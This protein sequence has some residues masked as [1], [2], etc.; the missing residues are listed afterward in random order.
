[1][2]TDSTA[3]GTA[4]PRGQLVTRFGR[5]DLDS[6]DCITFP[7]GLPGFEHCRRYA[8]LKSPEFEPLVCLH[9]VEGEPV[10]LLV[11]DP[12]LVLPDYRCVLGQTD[13]VRLGATADHA[14]LWLAVVTLDP[15]GQAFVNLRAPVVVNP[16]RMLG[17]QVMPHNS[18]YPL[19]HL[20]TSE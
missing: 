19:R 20:L 16:E 17:Y 1:M 8:I 15:S 5:F 14:L 9:A 12:R 13:L 4:P 18:L 11:V 10:S 3:A 2:I 6:S 7:L